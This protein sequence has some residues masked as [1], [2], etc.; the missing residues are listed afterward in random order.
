MSCDNRQQQLQDYVGNELTADS[1]SELELH[2]S[3]CESCR[4]DIAGYKMLARA[5]PTMPDPE[6]PTDLAAQVIAAVSPARRRPERE[7]VSA[8]RIRR[9]LKYLC[10]VA[11]AATLGTALWGW[12]ARIMDLA[13]SSIKSDL[14]AFGS[15]AKDLWYLINLLL[16]VAGVLQPTAHNFWT[17]IQLFGEPLVTYGPIFVLLYAGVLS[18]GAFLCWRALSYR[19]EGGLRH[20]S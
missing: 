1:A 19:G 5:L 8:T 12:A 10:A 9:A 11:F 16:E 2:L 14:V 18:L 17:N 20:V 7:P 3:Q 6:V 15:A 13:E 4:K